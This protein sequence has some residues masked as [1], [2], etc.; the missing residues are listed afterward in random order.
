MMKN[1]FSTIFPPNYY[2]VMPYV[3]TWTNATGAPG[4]YDWV[5]KGNGLY[6]PDTSI[7]GNSAYGLNEMAGVYNFYKVLSSTITVTVTAKDDN[8]V[9]L[10]IVPTT[11]VNGF[12]AA[13]QDGVMV[14]PKAKHKVISQYNGSKTLTNRMS[15]A[16]IHSVRDIDDIG[17]QATLIADPTHLWYWHVVTWNNDGDAAN[18]E[19]MVSIRYETI[20]SS[21]YAYTV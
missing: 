6:D 1:P 9:Q 3:Y 16:T 7:G 11:F 17:F 4:F 5:I 18:C 19:V 21:P 10:S 12:S 15:T 8:P 20:F 14:H 13:Q 2:T